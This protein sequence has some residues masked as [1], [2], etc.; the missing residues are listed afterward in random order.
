G[1]RSAYALARPPGHHA[2]AARAGGHC[3]VNNAALAAERLRARSANRVA[4]LDID[5][6]H[7]NGT[8][9]IF[10]RRGDV[11]F[12]SVHGDPGRYY[13]WFTGHAG[14]RGEGDGAGRNLNFPL[15]LGTGDPGWLEAVTQ[16]VNAARDFGADALVVSLGFDASEDEPLNALSVTAD[17]F[18]RA[19]E[20]IGALHLPTAI[21]QEGGYNVDVIGDLLERFLEGFGA[22]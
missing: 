8:Q 16:G 7:G 11:L 5:S 19:G 1:G 6:H 13:P 3:Y 9:G 12:V 22:G 14:E 4:I 17:G 18:A 15:A 10:W 20:I 2:Y 21:V